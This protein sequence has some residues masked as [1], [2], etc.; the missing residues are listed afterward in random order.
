MGAPFVTRA[1]R[2]LTPYSTKGVAQLI[3]PDLSAIAQQILALAEV[4]K[5]LKEPLRKRI[6]AWQ[7][8]RV[9]E[10]KA[11]APDDRDTPF[12]RLR[13]AIKA[14]G[15]VISR[16]RRAIYASIVTDSAYLSRHIYDSYRGKRGRQSRPEWAGTAWA[17]V[18]HEDITL[19][20]NHGQAKFME[21]PFNSASSKS[22][23][24]TAIEEA[25][26]EVKSE[27]ERAS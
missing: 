12:A 17:L 5:G 1:E 26:D 21:Q 22:D 13:D 27:V 2:G 3:G 25:W 6:K 24:D 23:I 10:M 4:D 7:A 16:S 18:A 20:H 9:A 19:K 11:L 15:V 8:K 14:K